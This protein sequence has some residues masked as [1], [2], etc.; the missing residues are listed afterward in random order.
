MS[1][2]CTHG[3]CKCMNLDGTCL[4]KHFSDCLRI[5]AG[6]IEPTGVPTDTFTGNK[7][8]KEKFYFGY[9][10]AG[11]QSEDASV[12]AIF[13]DGKLQNLYKLKEI[14]NNYS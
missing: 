11:E 10:L 9:D 2:Q 6:H 13:K 8:E 4:N 3:H 1:F 14:K 12:L 5:H 7:L